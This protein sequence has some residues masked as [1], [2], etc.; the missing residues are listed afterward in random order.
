M[1]CEDENKILNNKRSKQSYYDRNGLQIRP[2]KKQE[3]AW[4]NGCYDEVE[5][6]HSHFDSEIIAI[7]EFNEEKAG[8]GRLVKI[9]EKNFELGGMYVFEP[10][11]NKG[12]AKEIVTFLLTYVKPSQTVY[13]IP[14]EHLIHF[15]KQCG[16]ANC[17]EFESVPQIILDKYRWCH[18]K[19]T[20]PTTLLVLELNNR[21]KA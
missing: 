15:Y 20:H 1:M 10:F 2:A 12:I 14:F 5:F 6:V 16:F 11:R 17:S 3:I 19:Y 4:I 13:C 21:K 7:A 9:D 8:L 18:E